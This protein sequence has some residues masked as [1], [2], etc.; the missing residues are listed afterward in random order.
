MIAWLQQHRSTTGERA[1]RTPAES[2][3][4]RERKE[5]KKKERKKSRIRSRKTH[6]LAEAGFHLLS[7]STMDKGRIFVVKAVKSMRLLVDEGVVLRHKLPSDFRRNNGVG[8]GV[9]GGG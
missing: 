8:L 4:K 7:F 6:L 2:K 9:A 1:R 3:R 5:K